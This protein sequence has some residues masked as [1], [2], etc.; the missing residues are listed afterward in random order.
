MNIKQH[1]PKSSQTKKKPCS[2]KDKYFTI[3]LMYGIEKTLMKV[4]V[5]N[6]VMLS[7]G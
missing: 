2:Q 7:S 3:L 1:P 6:I 5:E 4:E